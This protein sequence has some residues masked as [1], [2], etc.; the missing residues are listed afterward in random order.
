MA[1]NTTLLKGTEI[2]KNSIVGTG[3]LVTKKFT[4]PNVLIVGSPAKV[5]KENVEWTNERI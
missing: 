1:T 3:A 2:P 5:V 4:N